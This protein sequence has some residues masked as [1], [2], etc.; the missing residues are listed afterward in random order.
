MSRQYVCGE[1]ISSSTKQSFSPHE[2]EG[3]RDFNR[4]AFVLEL[5]IQQIFYNIVS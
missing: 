3:Q 1:L 4:L 2:N 5:Q